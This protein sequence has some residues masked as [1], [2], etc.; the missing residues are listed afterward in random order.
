MKIGFSTLACPS[1]DLNKIVE[2]ASTMGYHGVEIRG[3]E[4]ELHLPL[5]PSLAGKP[6][7]VREFFS[8]KKVELVCLGTSAS[9][10]SRDQNDLI[11]QKKALV[12]FIELASN[13]ACPFV[14][15]IAGEVQKR[16][17]ANKAFHRMAEAL[18]GM[19]DV[20]AQRGVCLL[21]ENGGDFRDSWSMW[22]LCD[23]VDHPALRICWNQVN[24]IS[25]PEQATL[26]LPRLGTKIGLVHIADARF[27]DRGVLL[28][29]TPLGEGTVGVG[30]Q[31]EILKGLGYSGYL[32][33]EWPRLWVDGLAGPEAALPKAAEFLKAALSA[34]QPIL[35]A[36]K[37]DKNAPKYSQ[38]I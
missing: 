15:V 7:R 16:D 8:E 32:M 4:G 21:V 26:S 11:D 25:V 5:A 3:L 38:T 33:Y 6:D 24:A 27:D 29:H 12:E 28:E 34:K 2:Q 9:L 23:T 36:Y 19:A 17:T 1:W 10:T 31:I 30:R 20:A 35:S 22:Q 13:L 14:R 37:G 18:Q